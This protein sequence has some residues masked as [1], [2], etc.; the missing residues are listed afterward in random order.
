MSDLKPFLCRNQ[1][2][3]AIVGHCDHKQFVPIGAGAAFFKTV[4]SKCMQCG[5]GFKWHAAS[6]ACAE[7]IDRLV[8]KPE[9]RA[10]N[11]A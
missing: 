2:C 1:N 8:Q 10:G 4:R 11:L 5:H 7:T 9:V 3:R 6:P